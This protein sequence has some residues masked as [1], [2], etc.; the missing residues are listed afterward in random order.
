M[1]ANMNIC[2]VSTNTIRLTTGKIG[3]IAKR[4]DN[5]PLSE[6]IYINDVHATMFGCSLTFVFFYRDKRH[7]LLALIKNALFK[8]QGSFPESFQIIKSL[9]LFFLF[10]LR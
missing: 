4:F 1:Y 6:R 2:K 8:G 5:L 7:V 10:T 3:L 9:Q